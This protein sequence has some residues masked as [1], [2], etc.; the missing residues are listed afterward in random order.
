MGEVRRNLEGLIKIT[1][2]GGAG[3]CIL[4]QVVQIIGS[5]RQ[6]LWGSESKE[7]GCNFSVKNKTEYK[8]GHVLCMKGRGLQALCSGQQG[9]EVR[10]ERKFAWLTSYSISE[11][12]A[13]HVYREMSMMHNLLYCKNEVVLD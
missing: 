11:T 5:S 1:P 9:E 8:E 12:G 2:C 6:S 13:R 3:G 7:K 10:Q 4:E